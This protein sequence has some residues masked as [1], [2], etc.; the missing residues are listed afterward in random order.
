MTSVAMSAWTELAAASGAISILS[1]GWLTARAKITGVVAARWRCDG[2][3]G[4]AELPGPRLGGGVIEHDDEIGGGGRFEPP[5][6]PSPR[7]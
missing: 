6:A 3:Q 7:A 1:S 4:L 2:A 5:P